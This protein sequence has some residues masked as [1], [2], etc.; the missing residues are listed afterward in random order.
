[1]VVSDR[2]FTE[3]KTKFDLLG[4]RVA[5]LEAEEAREQKEGTIRPGTRRGRKPKT[6]ETET[7]EET[8]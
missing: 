1:M 6:E 8:E 3:F 7:T 4:A 2:E 5:K